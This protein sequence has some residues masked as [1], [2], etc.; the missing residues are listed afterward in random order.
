[1]VEMAKVVLKN[2][3]EIDPDNKAFYNANAEE[4]ITRLEELDQE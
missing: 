4:L 3:I 2:V 1:M